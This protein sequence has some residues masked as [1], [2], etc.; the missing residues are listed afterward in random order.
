[1][2]ELGFEKAVYSMY[3]NFSAR[4]GIECYYSA[5]DTEKCS[6]DEKKKISL[7]RAVQEALANIEKH[8]RA[9]RVHMDLQYFEPNLMVT[10]QDDGVGF[11]LN[12]VNGH[13]TSH[14]GLRG[15]EERVRLCGGSV[16]IRSRS[17]KGTVVS[18][19]VPVELS[20]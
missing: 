6:I 19:E 8:A 16:T 7:Y 11:Q 17:G 3:D 10:I 18:M 5:V 2:S 1:M 9:K 14:M 15:I 12:S 13:G 4:T 20:K